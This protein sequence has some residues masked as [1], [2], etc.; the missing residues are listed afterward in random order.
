MKCNQPTVCREILS[1]IRS[2]N[3]RHPLIFQYVQ[4]YHPLSQLS[5]NPYSSETRNRSG[6]HSDLILP[7]HFNFTSY[8]SINSLMNSL[9]RRCSNNAAHRFRIQEFYVLFH[10]FHYISLCNLARDCYIFPDR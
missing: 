9:A 10:R 7:A 3:S 1:R 2:H 5:S 8:I 6:K 4:Q